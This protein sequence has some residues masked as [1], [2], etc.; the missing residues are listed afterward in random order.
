MILITCEQEDIFFVLF[1]VQRT[2]FMFDET[3]PAPKGQ[4][5]VKASAVPKSLKPCKA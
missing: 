1:C 2:Y 5:V 3:T 4:L